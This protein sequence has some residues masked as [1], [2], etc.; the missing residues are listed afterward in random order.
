MNYF[1]FNRIILIMGGE[2][3]LKK[4]PNLLLSTII[5][6]ISNI[7]VRGLG[8]IYKIFLSNIIG[9]KG[10]GI[11]HIVFNFLMICIAI[12]STGLPT[13]LSCLISSANTTKNKHK[14]N[15]FFISALYISFFMALIISIIICFC[16]KFISLRLLYNENLNLFIL[17]ICPAIV[18][19]TLSNILRGYFYGIKKVMVPAL[20][21]ILEQLS[22]MIF[23]FLIFFYIKNK[24]LLCYASLLA[25]SVGEA[26]NIIYITINLYKDSN[27]YNRYTLNINDFKKSSIET[28]KM[29]LPITCNRMSG[30]VLQSV[31]S[32]MIPSRLTLCSL[33]YVDALRMYGVVSGMV[34]PFVYLPFSVGSALVVNLIPS[35]SQEV[36]LKNDKNLLKKIFCSILLTLAVGIF[37][38]IFFY[39]FATPLCDIVFNNKTAGIYLKAMF[40]A[41][42]FLSLNQTLSAILHALRKEFI[43]SFHSILGMSIQIILLYFLLPIP[44]LNIYAYIYVVTYVALFI[45]FLNSIS[46]ILELKRIKKSAISKV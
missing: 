11:Y 17:S 18:L 40:L 44:S 32:I 19:I 13:A 23:L 45:S 1:V 38:A 22:R 5:L 46:L 9:E 24:G 36:T 28:L 16:S 20:G 6:S 25:I 7:I 31:S 33:T 15:V 43:A 41:P 37:C 8:F 2:F 30:V 3:V 39:F 29:S 21:Q 4:I 34:I 10:L 26:V 42:I 14:T 35:I 12:T 27:L